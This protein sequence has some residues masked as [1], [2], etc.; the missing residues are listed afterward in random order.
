MLAPEAVFAEVACWEMCLSSGSRWLLPF[1]LGCLEAR[2]V[3]STSVILSQEA[4]SL[5]F[6][7]G[8]GCYLKLV[9]FLAND[10]TSKIYKSPGAWVAFFFSYS[11]HLFMVWYQRLLSGLQT[12]RRMEN[13]IHYLVITHHSLKPAD[14]H[15][16]LLGNT[17]EVSHNKV[18]SLTTR[19]LWSSSKEESVVQNR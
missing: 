4:A 10:D 6:K 11:S 17:E 15:C 1:G 3:Y 14:I 2:H 5:W 18:W 19:S 13:S 12:I 9:S 7:V 8:S 16:H